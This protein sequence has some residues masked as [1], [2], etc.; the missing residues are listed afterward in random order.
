MVTY[1]D[2]WLEDRK[3]SGFSAVPHYFG[4]GDYISL[5]LSN[6]R[7]Y[8][9]RIDDLLTVY[10]ADSTGDFVGCKIKGV[11]DLLKNLR[12]NFKVTIDDG[13][14]RL[15][16]LFLSA[17]VRSTAPSKEKYY[18]LGEHVGNVMMAPGALP[19]AA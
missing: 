9:K 11:C 6:G 15:G 10:Y 7:C 17:A 12:E 1:L 5:F 2:E 18:W 13:G 3:A 14:I 8:A 16:W 4:D 19:L